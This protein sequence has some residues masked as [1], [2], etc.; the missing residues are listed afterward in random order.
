ML[1]QRGRHWLSSMQYFDLKTYLPLDILTKVDR[2]SMAH[3]LEARVPLLDHRLVEFAATIPPEL[4][5]NGTGKFI[6]KQAMRG[7]LPDDIIDRPKQGFAV[8]LGHWFRGRLGGTLRDVLL[9]R[10]CRERGIFAPAAVQHLIELHERG[11][12]LDRQ[13]WTL[14][15]FELW[16]SQFLDRHAVPL[17]APREARR[18]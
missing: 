14:L 3:S 15:S 1:A 9:S 12:P 13:L 8:P 16:C 7:I 18:A 10:R 4:K 17:Q 2:M 5:L 11:R 6:F